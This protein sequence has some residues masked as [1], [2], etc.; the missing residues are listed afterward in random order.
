[1][2]STSPASARR[3]ASVTASPAIFPACSGSI[4]LRLP[5]PCSPLPI[6]VISASSAPRA[7][8]FSI[9]SGPI[10]RGSPSVTASR[11]RRLETDVDV[12][13]APQQ[14]EM[15]LDGELLAQPVADMILY[16]VEPQLPLGKAL[17]QL[18]HHKPR[19][20]RPDTHRKYWLQPGDRVRSDGLFVIGRELGDGEGIGELGLARVGVAPGKLVERCA[21][22]ERVV[23][24]NGVTPGQ[25]DLRRGDGGLNQDVARQDLGR[26]RALH[27][28]DVKA[29]LGPHDVGDRARPQAKRDVLELLDHHAPPEP[30]ARP[31][32]LP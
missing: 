18:E 29:E 25:G 5:A 16:F 22:G 15:V 20:R 11:G 28:D 4:S 2:A 31:T 27:L 21:V 8:A 3:T 1:M 19:P 9:T 12:R 30:A 32:L 24:R 23:T 6:K 17:R 14:V 26:L 7:S 13:G 10:P